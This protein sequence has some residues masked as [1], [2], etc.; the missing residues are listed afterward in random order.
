M[1][2]QALSPSGNTNPG[3]TNWYGRQSNNAALHRPGLRPPLSP[4]RVNQLDSGQVL[5]ALAQVDEVYRAPVA[6][7]YLQEYAYKEIAEILNVP[8]GTVKS[9][10]ARGI[11]RLQEILAGGSA[12]RK[13]QPPH[14]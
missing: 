11:A 3:G 14:D 2:T 10:I 8:M 7:F 6:L 1:P 4:A 12:R 13:G 5:K 9:R